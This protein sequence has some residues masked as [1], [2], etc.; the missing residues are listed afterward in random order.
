MLNRIIETIKL[1]GV[2]PEYPSRS[3]IVDW[4]LAW[5]VAGII[6]RDDR[7]LGRKIADSRFGYLFAHADARHSAKRH[8][9]QYEACHDPLCRVAWWIENQLRYGGKAIA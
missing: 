1:H 7:T 9:S 8:R 3:I 5:E 6:T 4:K 2:C